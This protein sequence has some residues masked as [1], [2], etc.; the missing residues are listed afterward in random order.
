MD[1]T[2]ITE[3]D[4]EQ[5][6]NFRVLV[7][8]MSN[9]VCFVHVMKPTCFGDTQIVPNLTPE[10]AFL[11]L[12]EAGRATVADWVTAGGH[13]IGLQVNTQA[14]GDCVVLISQTPN[15]KP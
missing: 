11:S 2:V 15:L 1:V 8:P 6:A 14:G 5:L 4:L 7:R 3:N 10:A 9:I 12:G 13:Y